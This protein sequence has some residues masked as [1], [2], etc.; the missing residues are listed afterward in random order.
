MSLAKKSGFGLVHANRI[1]STVPVPNCQPKIEPRQCFK[2]V[3]SD[4]TKFA[5]LL[6]QNFESK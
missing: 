6:L 3:I 2:Y 5:S 4:N 1:A